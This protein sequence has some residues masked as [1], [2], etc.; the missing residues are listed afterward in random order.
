MKKKLIIIGIVVLVLVVGVFA[1]CQGNLGLKNP[2][3]DGQTEEATRG[4]LVIPVT[5]TGM[6]EPARLI[7]IKSKA[8]GQVA[9]IHVVEGQMVKAGDLLVTLDPIDETR[10]VEVTRASLDRAESAKEKA[11]ITLANYRADLPRLTRLAQARLDETEA[12]LADAEYRYNRTKE[13]LEKDVAS[14]SEEV[15]A[16]TAYQTAKARR[17]AA[18]VEIER[19]RNNEDI[20]IRGGQEDVNQAAAAM[21]E[22]QKRLDEAQTR[23]D[24][25]KV[26]AKSDGMV[27]SILVREGEMI[28]SG[29]ISL[30]GGTALMFLADTSAMFVMAQVDEADIGSIRG[31][32]PEYARPGRTQKLAE[33]VYRQKAQEV[34]AEFQDRI[35]EVTVDAYRSETYQGVIERILPE[36]IRVSSALA[37]RVRVRL[38]GED[39]DKLMGLQADLSFTTEKQEGVVLVK[40][41]A[42]HSEGRKCFVYVPVPG[43]PRDE[44]KVPVE[45]G[46]T[47]GTYTHIESGLEAGDLIFV[48]RPHK[49][50]KEKRASEKRK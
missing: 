48:K 11:E 4:D 42:L 23:L 18:R 36:P 31:I 41:D 27:Y 8:S 47:D 9:R 13:Y 25:T 26:E 30:M 6:V 34:V 19:A 38:V 33:E 1:L 45:I 17:D 7:E 35:V 20:L 5:A 14:E 3:L 22:S 16:K 29:T 44:E 10:N 49:T 37:F 43:K 46:K 40:N 12:G 39:L 15:Y 21:R 28:Q 24:E 2:W 32:A 50:E